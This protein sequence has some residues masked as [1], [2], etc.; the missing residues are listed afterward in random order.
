MTLNCSYVD[1][2]RALKA[3]PP[4]LSGWGGMLRGA[5]KKEH[6]GK[7]I[8]LDRAR[9]HTTTVELAVQKGQ[10][11]GL[12]LQEEEGTK[13]LCGESKVD[14]FPR[15]RTLIRKLLFHCGNLCIGT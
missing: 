13:C 7:W 3:I 4:Q 9:G 2:K 6:S 10:A 11:D 5:D 12:V 8:Q 14:V 1:G 15:Y